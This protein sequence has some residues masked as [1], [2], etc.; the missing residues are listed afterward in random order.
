MVDVLMASGPELNVFEAAAVGRVDRVRELLDADPEVARAWA[1]DGFTALQLAA[2][3]GHPEIV[4]LLLDR[5]A[6]V[7]AVA[8]NDMGV[9]PLHAACASGQVDVARMLLAHGAPI[10]AAEHGGYTPLH[11]A[12]G[13]GDVAL[14]R[15]L[16]GHGA[17]PA[18]PKADGQTPRDLAAAKGDDELVALLSDAAGRAAGT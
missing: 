3:F 7:R 2:F 15:L 10:D 16:L 17:D 14:A 8:R 5:G 9:M 11:E 13:R 1:P 4:A 6:D 12:A 18:L